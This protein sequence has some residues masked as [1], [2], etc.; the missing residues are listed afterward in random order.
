MAFN[1]V[2][3]IVSVTPSDPNAAT[4]ATYVMAGLGVAGANAWVLTPQSTGRILLVATGVMTSGTTGS[5]CTVQLSFGTGSAPANAAAVTGTQQGGQVF[6]TSLTGVLTQAFALST[7]LTG[8]ALSTAL[9][10]DIAQKS[11]GGTLQLQKLTLVGI[12]L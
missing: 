11:S 4:S 6:I 2:P 5:T 10:F 7:V 3:G 9:W 12:E 8:Q 1:P